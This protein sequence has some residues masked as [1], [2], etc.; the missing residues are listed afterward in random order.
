MSISGEIEKLKA[1]HAEGTLSD[2]EFAAAKKRV[3]SRHGPQRDR[4]GLNWALWTLVVVVVVA[5]GA[6]LAMLD[7]ISRSV[8]MIAGGVGLVGAAAACV[9]SVAEDLS[10]TAAFGFGLAGLAIGAVAFAALS[11]ILIPAA[12]AL[13]AIGAL[14]SWFG[15]MFT[16]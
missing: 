9:M 1:Q 6:A 7:E 5:S 8:Q 16:D 15:D 2:A 3:L 10:L 13:L 14:W 12:L 11:P 4:G